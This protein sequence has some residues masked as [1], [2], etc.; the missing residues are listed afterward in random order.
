MKVLF[1]VDGSSDAARAVSDV[2][3][4]LSPASD[5]V[6][7]YFAPPEVHIRHAH[8]AEAMRER[9]RRAIAEAVF[10]DVKGLLPPALVG[11]ASTIVCEHTPCEGILIEADKWNA[12]LIVVGA[13]GLTQVDKWVLG[14]VADGV[15]QRSKRPVFISRPRP[16]DRAGQPFRILYAY[17]GSACCTSALRAAEQLAWPAETTVTA[18]TVVEGRAAGHVPKWILDKARSAD[19]EAMATAWQRECDDDKRQAHD[20]LAAFMAKQVGPFGK[21]ETLVAE[22]HAADQILRLADER[23]CDVIL[24]GARGRGMLERL[25]IGST[26][27]RVLNHSP[28]SIL[29]VRGS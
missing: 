3:P 23:K 6:G 17:D 20:E 8:D 26:S 24:M 18:L 7:F 27:D 19:V 1:A 28:C 16:A 13:R 5:T 25:L 4:L 10:G 11:S 22:G 15:A 14:S 29:I 21:A 12:D 2:A 9:A